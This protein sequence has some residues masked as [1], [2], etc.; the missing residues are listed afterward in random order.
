M[1]NDEFANEVMYVINRLRAVLETKLGTSRN[2][3]PDPLPSDDDLFDM[4]QLD[5]QS[6]FDITVSILTECTG[7][8]Y[9]R[10][11]AVLNKVQTVFISMIPF[12][13]FNRNLTGQYWLTN[14]SF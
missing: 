5:K 2:D 10:I 6:R 4:D 7:R 13:L 12:H 11:A 14:N 8:G 3:N 9:D 1:K